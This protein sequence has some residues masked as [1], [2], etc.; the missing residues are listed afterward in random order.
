MSPVASEKPISPLV[1]AE[2]TEIGKSPVGKDGHSMTVKRLNVTS[3]YESNDSPNSSDQ[4]DSITTGDDPS[5][6][7]SP[8]THVCKSDEI[9]ATATLPRTIPQVSSGAL[10]MLTLPMLRPLLSKAQGC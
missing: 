4:S 5:T 8:K 9:N 6:G 1:T 7:P 10:Y 3:D 2:K